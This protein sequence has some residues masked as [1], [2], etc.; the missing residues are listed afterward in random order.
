[1]FWRGW[2]GQKGFPQY[3]ILPRF[4]YVIR[5]WWNWRS[6]IFF[7]GLCSV[8]S[9]ESGI[10]SDLASNWDPSPMLSRLSAPSSQGPHA[11]V[12][13]LKSRIDLKA[14]TGDDI[15]WQFSSFSNCLGQDGGLMM[16]RWHGV[17]RGAFFAWRTPIL[18]WPRIMC[19][20]VRILKFLESSR[21]MP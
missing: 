5:N 11:T 14:F 18:S 3:F 21:E 12:A 7:V 6:P 10:S 1:M 4:L 2:W 9:R 17:D 16:K 8:A 13:R 15:F 19:S 20:Q